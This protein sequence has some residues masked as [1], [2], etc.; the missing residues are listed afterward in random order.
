MVH[1]YLASI[2][3]TTKWTKWT[4]ETNS[5]FTAY[6]LKKHLL[7]MLWNQ[8]TILKMNKWKKTIKC[9]SGV[10]IGTP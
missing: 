4:N 1:T 9:F 6:V 5:E 7:K 10:P 3:K 2:R 8:L